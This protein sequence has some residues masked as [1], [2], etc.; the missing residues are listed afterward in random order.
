[1]NGTI[2]TLKIPSAARLG[3][4]LVALVAAMALGAPAAPAKPRAHVAAACTWTTW[5]IYQRAGM[6]C[7]GAKKALRLTLK[8]V[9]GQLSGFVCTRKPAGGACY[10]VLSNAKHFKYKRS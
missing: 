10:S 2:K 3:V 7:P 4:V 5:T 9:K 1:M 6:S 8:P